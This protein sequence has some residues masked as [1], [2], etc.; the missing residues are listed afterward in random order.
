MKPRFQ[1]RFGGVGRLY[2]LAAL[3]KFSCSKIA[4]VG[5]GGVGSW[6]AEALARSGIGHLILIDADDLCI[7][8]TNRQIHALDSAYGKNKA[9]ELAERLQLINPDL[10]AT[11]HPRFYTQASAEEVLWAH[12]P[13]A[14][15]D[16]IDSI[17]HKCHLLAQN[18]H[19]PARL[20][21]SGAA[22]GR[23]DLT[24]VQLADLAEVTHDPLL[25]SVRRTLRKEFSFP[26]G[27]LKP[28]V[29]FGIKAVFSTEDPVYPQPDGS[30]NPERP[31]TLSAALRCNAGFGTITHL[32]ATFGNLLA[33]AALHDLSQ[34]VPTDS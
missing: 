9:A 7:T 28:P 16:A 23:K 18:P 27:D 15:L 2:G 24:K 33:S 32:T 13:V 25:S 17:P 10:E 14:V 22:G 19:Q 1:D 4:V 20:Y 6:A 21:T 30:C 5:L 29:P 3:E 34:S 26:P 8:N 12:Q 31:P 11:V